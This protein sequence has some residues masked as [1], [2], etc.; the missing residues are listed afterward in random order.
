MK[1]K[2]IEINTKSSVQIICDEKC[3]WKKLS[4][5]EEGTIQVRQVEADVYWKTSRYRNLLKD[6]QGSS[7]SLVFSIQAK[8]NEC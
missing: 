2:S 8:N 3:Q 1:N 7:V 5:S 4:F 6:K